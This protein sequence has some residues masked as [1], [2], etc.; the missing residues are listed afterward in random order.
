[1]HSG[2]I[3]PNPP[4]DRDRFP[5]RNTDILVIGAGPAGLSVGFELKRRR[6]PFL[7]LEQGASVGESWR[8]MP[9][10]LKLVS[11][12][13]CNSLAGTAKKLF[14]SHYEINREEFLCY[15]QSYAEEKQLPVQI[16]TEVYG[17]EK[18]PDGCF[19]VRTSQG[20]IL[21]RVL[22]NATGYFSNP[23]IPAIP[24]ATESK[25]PQLHF[26]H[27]R[28]PRHIASFLRVSSPSKPVSLSPS[29]LKGGRAGLRRE[30][31][32]SI[33]RRTSA[34]PLILIVGKRL[35]AGQLMVELADAG[36]DVALSRR[37]PIQYG[38]E[39]WAWWFLFR[40]FPWLEWL[41]LKWKGSRAPGNDVR[42]RGGV[43]RKLIES[44]T[45][46]T[47]PPI[48][49]FEGD[50]VTFENGQQLQPGAVLYAT[51]FRPAL[52]HLASLDISICVETGRPQLRDMESVSM[53]GLYFIGLDHGRNFQSRFIRGIRKDAAFL[54]KRLERNVLSP[55][56][57]VT[58][59]SLRT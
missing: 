40:I 5:H 8:N 13:K 20:E 55:P 7:I 30:N 31:F 22:V 38:A 33:H 45:V 26:A 35:S 44:G 25:I 9:R 34:R 10:R 43:A 6:L 56:T 2:L 59:P 14:P 54:V 29:L 52:G 41:K 32:Q 11:P 1:M 47:F 46:K 24:G 36:F 39:P 42:M 50:T 28:D 21:P 51:G 15:L 19:R 3:S 57:A 4:D 17:V 23:F 49:C 58:Q 48:K 37:S 16:D 53:P 27:Y 12:W 18:L